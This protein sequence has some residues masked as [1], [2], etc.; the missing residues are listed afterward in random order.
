MKQ[1]Y[2]LDR[3]NLITYRGQKKKHM[4]SCKCRYLAKSHVVNC[5]SVEQTFE[6]V[7][8]RG[9]V[10]TRVKFCKVVFNGCDFWGVTFK[11]CIFENVKISASVL[12]GCIFRNCTFKDTKFQYTTIVNTSLEQID[13]VVFLN[14]VKCYNEYP[15][16]DLS[17][18]LRKA[19][20]VVK[21]NKNL[22]KCKLLHLSGDRVNMLNIY[23]LLKHH[24]QN[25]LSGL[26]IE[27]V[28]HSTKTITT[29]KKLDISLKGLCQSGIL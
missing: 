22:R 16:C 28:N 27:L 8:F 12:M 1:A 26:L 10:F 9:S 11:N 4:L 20:E 21:K 19:L 23:L 2:I 29:Y 7:N 14:G 15:R 13:N 24:S 5:D 17:N 6:F 18:E 3:I 25:D